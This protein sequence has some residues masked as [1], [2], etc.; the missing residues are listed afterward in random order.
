MGTWHDIQFCGAAG[1]GKLAKCALESNI[2][3]CAI[4]VNA[5]HKEYLTQMFTTFVLDKLHE[6][7]PN[8]VPSG[9]E[10]M[11]RDKLPKDLHAYH[12]DHAASFKMPKLTKTPEMFTPKKN[13]TCR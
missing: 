1:P 4:A 10:D 13:A 7:A 3:V 9:F 5:K 12:D 8:F 2:D 6:G 11:V